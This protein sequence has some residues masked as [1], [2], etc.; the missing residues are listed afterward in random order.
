MRC[1]AAANKR[2]KDGNEPAY[3]VTRS[4]ERDGKF[5]GI[6]VYRTDD[7]PADDEKSAS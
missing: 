1:N 3:Y 2:A 5:V 7:R 6:A 4:V